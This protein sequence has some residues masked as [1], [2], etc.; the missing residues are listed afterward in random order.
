MVSQIF[1]EDQR[2]IL[3]HLNKREGIFPPISDALYRL[4][5]VTVRS[6]PQGESPG[7]G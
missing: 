7:N 6:D 5:Q 1:L 4:D 2:G 3:K